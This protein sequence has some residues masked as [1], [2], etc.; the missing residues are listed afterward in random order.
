[1]KRRSSSQL[2]QEQ[3]GQ[4]Q[5]ANTD[6]ESQSQ[7]QSDRIIK[8]SR[9]NSFD[10]TYDT[11]SSPETSEL[12]RDQ[13]EF[14]I[15]I[16]GC[17]Q[18]ATTLTFMFAE[19]NKENV[20]KR[21]DQKSGK[22]PSD[23]L[24]P[25]YNITILARENSKRYD[26]ISGSGSFLMDYREPKLNDKGY[27]TR[28]KVYS[29]GENFNI[30]HEKELVPA[31]D[32]VINAFANIPGAYGASLQRDIK[33]LV[34]KSQSEGKAPLVMMA[35]NGVPA[36]YVA[37]HC[38]SRMHS[39]MGYNADV[40]PI[41]TTIPP[42]N[43]DE[44]AYVSHLR[45]ELDFIN[46]IGKEKIVKCVLNLACQVQIRDG[47][48]MYDQYKLATPLNKV[49]MPSNFAFLGEASEDEK[50]QIGSFWDICENSR[51][52]TE[53]SND[54]LFKMCD[55][56]GV[57]AMNPITAATGLT[58]G[59]VLDHPEYSSL[60]FHMMED[61]QKVYFGGKTLMTREDMEERLS[62]SRDHNTSMSRSF[63]MGGEMET[64]LI[65]K[66]EVSIVD[67]KD[68]DIISIKNFIP[69]LDKMVRVRDSKISAG[70]SLEEAVTNARSSI[71]GDLSSHC[72]R[73]SQ[74]YKKQ[75]HG[76][77]P[78][79]KYDKRAQPAPIPEAIERDSSG[80]SNPSTSVKQA[81]IK[82]SLSDSS[83]ESNHSYK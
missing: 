42:R 11:P 51:I 83:V 74:L 70:S 60:F 56:L 49:E 68:I 31:P 2:S 4:E 30:T 50:R 13:D 19:A 10:Y 67:N 25:K 18:I 27:D 5:A 46:M 7:S 22:L 29:V 53:G 78:T 71:V 41:P 33:Y 47:K 35:D 1:M 48:A 55:K 38:S 73:V 45:E 12:Q 17:G 24:F 26:V 72:S 16:V 63:V 62:R 15:T 80:D 81:G 59:E 36:W 39:L 57:S 40:T 20:I 21:Q 3:A 34:D 6:I 75:Q 52:Q 43:Q 66:R 69:I 23:K 32:F 8:R 54:L 65:L 79:R 76:Y 28:T 37:K 58:I 82:R 14:N 64:N 44:A 61:A 77:V 9:S